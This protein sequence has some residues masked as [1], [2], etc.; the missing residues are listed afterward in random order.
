MAVGDIGIGGDLA[1]DF[2]AGDDGQIV[3]RAKVEG[4]C[5]EGRRYVPEKLFIW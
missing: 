3:L 5:D 1:G 2:G 4:G